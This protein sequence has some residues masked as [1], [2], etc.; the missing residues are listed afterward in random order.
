MLHTLT[1]GA[2]FPR[3]LLSVTVWSTS[4]PT[5][6]SAVYSHSC[7]PS[8]CSFTQHNTIAEYITLHLP[9][10][11]LICIFAIAYI[12]GLLRLRLRHVDRYMSTVGDASLSHLAEFMGDERKPLPCGNKSSMRTSSLMFQNM[13]QSKENVTGNSV[14]YQ[15]LH[16]PTIEYNTAHVF[17]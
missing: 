3:E 12:Q 14:Q 13:H 5:C 8:V 2:K 6:T 15:Q 9:Q 4:F 11:S 7:I 17:T 1:L 10:H 16:T